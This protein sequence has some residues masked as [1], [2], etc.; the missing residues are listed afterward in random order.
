[1]TVGKCAE[2]EDIHPT[3]VSTIGNQHLRVLSVSPKA[4]ILAPGYEH[5]S[6]VEDLIAGR[7]REF[8][9]VSYQAVFKRLLHGD[10]LFLPVYGLI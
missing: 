7:Q 1:M 3:K 10:A 5:V 4:V 8:S 9:K 6:E 2:T